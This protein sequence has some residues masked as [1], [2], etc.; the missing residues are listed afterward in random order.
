MQS[1]GVSLT[2]VPGGKDIADKMLIADMLAYALDRPTSSTVLVLVSADPSLAYPLSILRLRGYHVVVVAPAETKPDLTVQASL[3]FD[4]NAEVL[5]GVGVPPS[6]SSK[7]KSLAPNATSSSGGSMLPST[8][9]RLPVVDSSSTTQLD[10]V[11][12]GVEVTL[13]DY[14]PTGA[15][16]SASC[17]TLKEESS[18]LRIPVAKSEPQE[19]ENVA[20]LSQGSITST[21]SGGS[22]RDEAQVVSD[23]REPPGTI[24]GFETPSVKSEYTIEDADFLSASSAASPAVSP[25]PSFNSTTQD[26]MPSRTSPLRDAEMFTPEAMT[27]AEMFEAAIF[28]PLTQVLREALA[29]GM[30]RPI[31]SH[32]GAKLIQN[33]P[34]VYKNAGVTRFAQYIIM[35]ESSGVIE[36]GGNAGAA[37]IK[38]VLPDIPIALDPLVQ[39]LREARDEGMVHPLRS[40]I[41]A[42]LVAKDAIVY[43]KAGV[44][45]FS[46]YITIAEGMGIVEVGG[47]DGGA[48]IKLHPGLLVAT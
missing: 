13:E 19:T 17:A 27:D 42:K 26:S 7:V 47:Q 23:P 24:H 31:R 40:Y 20:S 2:D 15:A 14:F 36:T 30:E 18:E 10:R 45:R 12:N 25:Q 44:T 48:W 6:I 35:A 34:Q 46:Q 22:Q 37:W 39:V 28:Q 16:P 41:G 11:S 9:N 29:E 21:S 38:L 4:W 43:K 8:S 32:I 33:D 5:G 3:C 1:S